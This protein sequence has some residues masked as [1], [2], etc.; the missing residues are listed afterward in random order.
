MLSILRIT[1]R[2]G[3]SFIDKASCKFDN[4]KNTQPKDWVMKKTALNL[5]L[6]SSVYWG[7]AVSG[8]MS[9]PN[10]T[11]E[12]AKTFMGFYG[13]INV[14][15]AF[16]NT[17]TLNTNSRNIQYCTVEQG[18]LNANTISSIS[19]TSAS[20]SFSLSDSSFL[21]GGQ[22][23]YN[24]K[25]YKN[26]I[27]GLETDIQGFGK[28]NQNR[29]SNASVNYTTNNKLQSISTNIVT[30][31]NIDFIGSLRGKLGYL[32]RSNVSIYGTGG[33]AYGNVG[34]KTNIQQSYGFLA[35]TDGIA[36]NWGSAGKYSNTRVGFALGG[37]LEWM[38]RANLS[39][40]IEY[41]YYN[42]G[43]VTYNSGNLVDVITVPY[44]PQ[45]YFTNTMSSTTRF[46]G[47]ILR[48]GLNY[49]FA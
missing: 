27:I 22:V 37:A 17:K 33:L 41:L 43:D 18:C 42:L 48:L 34:S 19:A 44:T 2:R 7:N 30:S 14:G 39:A 1:E 23:G 20:S 8:Q 21:G 46:D 38:F 13:G 45:N 31:K 15:D 6:L 32:V 25:M 26:Y 47:N 36:P 49:H 3:Y 24:H 10:Q 29:S 4:Q 16:A 12:S 5:V 11:E 28:R 35:N 9:T 40:K